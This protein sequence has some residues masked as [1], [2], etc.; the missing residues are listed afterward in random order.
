MSLPSSDKLEAISVHLSTYVKT[1]M[2]LLKLEVLERGSSLG[3]KIIA[4]LLIL[5]AVFLLLLFASL[6]AG[7][8]LSSKLGDTYSGF[9]ILAAFYLLV[10]ILMLT[11]RRRYMERAF[12]N[13]MVHKVLEK[14]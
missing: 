8:Y 10:A 13:R 9:L 11:I 3:A 12:R 4:N 1:N 5:F 6:G 7:F 2:E 14:I